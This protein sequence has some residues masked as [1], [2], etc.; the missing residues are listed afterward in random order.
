M[1]GFEAD[2][3]KFESHENPLQFVEVDDL[4]QFGLIPEF[5]GGSPNR[6]RH[7]YHAL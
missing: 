7:M 1:V 4:I 5:V 6:R 2:I 3:K